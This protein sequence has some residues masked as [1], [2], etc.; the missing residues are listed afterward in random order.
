MLQTDPVAR[1]VER[2]LFA[3]SVLEMEEEEL[4]EQNSLQKDAARL[5]LAAKVAKKADEYR[6]VL[7][8]A[9][10]IEALGPRPHTN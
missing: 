3:R 1:A 4:E 5:A 7:G 6:K 10:T 9:T 8:G 2:E